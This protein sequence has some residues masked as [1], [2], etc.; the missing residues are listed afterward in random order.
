MQI[1][2]ARLEEAQLL[3][4]LALRSKAHWG[5]DD[6]FLDACRPVLMVEASSI[7]SGWV[8]VVEIA[9]C[10]AGFYSLKP[11]EDA[12]DLDMLF[13]DPWA[14]GQG[15]GAR[16]F[17]HACAMAQRLGGT[18]LIVESDPNAEAFY[19]RMGMA[20]YAERESSVQAGRWL[21]L[22]A[23]ELQREKPIVDV[24]V[25]MAARADWERAQAEGAYRVE[26]LLTA[27]FIHFSTPAQVAR[28]ANAIYAGR[29]DLVL[30]V[31]DP[32]RLT[33]TL[34]YE[35]PTG[36]YTPGE[37]LFPHL[38]GPLNLDAV[39]RVMPYLPDAN[40]TFAPPSL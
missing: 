15:C 26:S 8:Y 22:L 19:V 37:E 10:S 9:E 16:L 11:L 25:H 27:G 13:V 28:V 31:V 24:I 32:S 17:A 36:T 7:E 34:K 39:V 20:R 21:P 29:A 4:E 38:Y 30:L 2:P 18:R 3:S 14:I 1:R 23:L 33:A 5:Y 6:A 35:P 40:G 12:I